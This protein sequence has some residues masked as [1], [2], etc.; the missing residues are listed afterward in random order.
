M[1][2]L[3][4]NQSGATFIELLLYIAIFLILTPILLSVSINAVR[5]EQ[6]HETEKQASMDSQFA[7]ERMY[8]LVTSTKKVDVANSVFNDMA[9]K[10]TLVMQDDSVVVIEGNLE[11][12]SVDITEGGL[13]TELSSENLQLEGLYFERITDELG[14]PEIVMGVNVRLNAHGLQ[15]Y[16]VLQEYIASAN[17]ERGDFD[18]DGCPDFIDTF[19]RHPACC[20]DSDID[21]ICDELDNCVYVY[22][23]FQ[24]DFDEDG[25]G[26]ACDSSGE[27]SPFN[28]TPNRRS[29][30]FLLGIRL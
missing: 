21:D 24:A 23:P 1:L 11:N 4:K 22:N 18:G 28:C 2:K 29:M 14:D 25:L 27:L 9:G 12:K 26:D 5:L 3:L 6:Q 15:E 16:A 19:P 13:V 7:M 17:L 10:L 20:G 30:I 8:D